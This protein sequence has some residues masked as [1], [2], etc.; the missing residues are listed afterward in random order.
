VGKDN[1]Y[2]T[3]GGLL[4]ATGATISG[5]ITATSGYI[6]GWQINSKSIYS[7]NTLYLHSGTENE[8][9]ATFKIPTIVTYW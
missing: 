7:K 2:V 9:P 3:Y 6:G 4:N 1:F 8:W 5:N